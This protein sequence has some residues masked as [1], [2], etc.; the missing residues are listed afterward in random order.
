MRL[1]LALLSGATSP[2]ETGDAN[3]DAL[4]QEYET[5]CAAVCKGVLHL[6]SFSARSRRLTCHV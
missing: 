4:Q 3:V 5:E 6:L 1:S 2:A